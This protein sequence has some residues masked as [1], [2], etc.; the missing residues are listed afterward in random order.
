[1]RKLNQVMRRPNHAQLTAV[2][3]GHLQT[4]ITKLITWPQVQDPSSPPPPTPAIAPLQARVKCLT[5]T[6]KAVI[7]KAIYSNIRH[8]YEGQLIAV[9]LRHRLTIIT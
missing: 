2:K 8:P 1:M 9:N 3:M 6:M 5:H 4:T 7:V